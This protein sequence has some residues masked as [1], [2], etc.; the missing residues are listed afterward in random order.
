M[1][2]HFFPSHVVEAV[3]EALWQHTL[4]QAAPT[5]FESWSPAKVVAD[6]ENS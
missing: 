5:D 4:V 6:D 1:P 3:A 2:K